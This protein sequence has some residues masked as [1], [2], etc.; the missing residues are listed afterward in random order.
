MTAKTKK[1]SPRPKQPAPDAARTPPARSTRGN[2]IVETEEL[3]RRLRK[4]RLERRLTLKQVER[5]AGLSATHLSEIERGRTSPTIGALV[6]IARALGKDT[7][8]FIEREER[9]DVVHLHRDQAPVLR[10]SPGV[11]A[12]LLTPGIPGSLLYA[13][14]LTL[15]PGPGRTGEFFIAAEEFDGEALYM[16]RQGR[17]R[18][19]FG[20]AEATLQPGDGVQARMAISHRLRPMG[21]TPVDLVAIFNRSLDRTD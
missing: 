10:P 11:E 2:A 17:V 13:Y 19:T 9:G 14:R 4:L 21:N 6:R 12:R 18:S 20:E 7:S 8:Y 3:G 15:T 1:A 5:A 16:V